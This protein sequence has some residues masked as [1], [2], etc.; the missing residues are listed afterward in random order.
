MKANPG[1]VML[2]LV[3]AL[4]A[5]TGKAPQTS[6]VDGY[7]DNPQDV[8]D[9]RDAVP[10]QE[11]RS[12]YGNPVRYTVLGNTY[13]TLDSSDGFV[14]RGLASFYG[15]KFQGRRTSSGEPYDMYAMTAAHKLLPLPTYV[16]VTNL[17]NGRRVVVKVNDRGPFH[18]G[19][20]IDLSY[21]AAVKLGIAKQGTGRV[22][23]RAIDPDNPTAH[24]KEDGR[25]PARRTAETA[26]ATSLYV[27]AGAFS[28]RTNAET[29]RQQLSEEHGHEVVVR[30]RNNKGEKMY[31][32][33]L[34]PLASVDEAETLC[35]AL[36]RTGIAGAHPVV[37]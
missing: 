6:D 12:R 25:Q 37:D 1:L 35:Q 8:A 7:P 33:F 31:R 15:T 9:V 2:P 20:V 5:C 34:G 24:R 18:A 19:R 3:A 17:D 30:P 4:G 16:E 28:L 13:R 21:A 32:V 23:V 14:E 22:E 27:Q 26:D 36:R 29:L 11:P 10:T